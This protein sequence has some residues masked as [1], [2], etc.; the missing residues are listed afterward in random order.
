M[1]KII[2]AMLMLCATIFVGCDSLP[3]ADKMTFISKEIGSATALVLNKVSKINETNKIVIINICNEIKTIVP[4]TNST[5]EVVW[6]P[7]VNNHLAKLLADKKISDIQKD[8]IEVSFIA[9]VK[10]LD[11]VVDVKYSKI[12]AYQNLLDATTIGFITGFL[13]KYN[14][15]AVAAAETNEYDA[16]AYEYMSTLIK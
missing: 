15:T 10:T 12:R 2:I 3:S 8:V 13:S 5:F 14:V 16:A 4:T 7:V 9:A 11:H 6:T 1:K